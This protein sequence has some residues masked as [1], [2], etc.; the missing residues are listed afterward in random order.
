MTAA[1]FF[2]LREM[3]FENAIDDDKFMGVLFGLA[4]RAKS[5]PPIEAK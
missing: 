5:R 2:K 3:F 1:T 4:G